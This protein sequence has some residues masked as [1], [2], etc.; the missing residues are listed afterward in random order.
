VETSEAARGDTHRDREEVE[1]LSGR[2]A[3][4]RGAL[5]H[6]QLHLDHHRSEIVDVVM[7]RLTRDCVEEYERGRQVVLLGHR[8]LPLPKVLSRR[9][10]TGGEETRRRGIPKKSSIHAHLTIVIDVPCRIIMSE[11]RR[12]I[13]RETMGIV[14]EAGME[15]EAVVVVIKVMVVITEAPETTTDMPVV[16]VVA[17]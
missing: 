15:G 2:G 14:V 4:T 5:E 17:D 3:E 6:H 9:D 12:I 8:L 13:V 16:A 1:K 7:L 10:Q 11:D